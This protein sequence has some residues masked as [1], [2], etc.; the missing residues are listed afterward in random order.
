MRKKIIFVVN[1]ADFFISHRLDIGLKAKSEGI[2]VH[3]ASPGDCPAEIANAGFVYHKIDSTRSGMNPISELRIIFSLIR[4][5]GVEKP[6]LVH[7][8]TMKPYLY[9]GIAARVTGVESVVSSVAGLG[10]LFS[11]KTLKTKLLR[12]LLFPLFKFS[13]GHRK[14]RTI[15][16]NPDDRKALLNLGFLK[17]ENTVLIR[18]AGVSLSNFPIVSEPTSVPV[19][20][21]ASRLLIDKGV[22]Q[23]VEASEILKNRGIRVRF[24]LIGSTDCAN[25]NSVSEQQLSEWEQKGLVELFGQRKDIPYLF[26]QSNIITLPSFYGEGLPK[27][28]LEAAASGRAVVTTDHPGCR[29]AIDV[30]KTGILVP[31]KDSRALADAIQFLLENSVVR[32]KMAS[33]GRLLAERE[34]DVQNVAMTHMEIYNELL[35]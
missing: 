29:D 14:Q 6:D 34:F 23:F 22:C 15:F 21:Y 10:I 26:S 1:D 16:Q 13:F 8:I 3:I 7:L 19:I 2:D 35:T 24:W 12:M 27:V 28:L 17:L 25:S 4:L 20:S 30:G 18:G 9:G 11:S 31:V 33:Y 32:F 5:F